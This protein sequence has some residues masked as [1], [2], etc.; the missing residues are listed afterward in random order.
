MGTTLEF[1]RRLDCAKRVDIGQRF[2][3]SE[4][5]LQPI[6]IYTFGL[7]LGTSISQG[8]KNSAEYPLPEFIRGVKANA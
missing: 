8:S 7:V 2:G 6:L 1:E 4:L 3:K 5:S